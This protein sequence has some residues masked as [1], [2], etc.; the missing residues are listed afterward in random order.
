MITHHMDQNRKKKA[1]NALGYRIEGVEKKFRL[2]IH[3]LTPPPPSFFPSKFKQT[4]SFHC[5]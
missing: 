2:K 3:Y 1:I 5:C 4:A